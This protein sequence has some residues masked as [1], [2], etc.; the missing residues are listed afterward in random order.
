MHIVIID[1]PWR[2]QSLGGA[3]LVQSNLLALQIRSCTC[4]CIRRLL[5]VNKFASSASIAG[6]RPASKIC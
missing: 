4:S 6:S 3:E 1:Q 2:G 5:A